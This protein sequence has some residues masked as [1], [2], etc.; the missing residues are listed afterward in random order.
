MP[1]LGDYS[2]QQ[3]IAARGVGTVTSLVRSGR[4]IGKSKGME[5][6]VDQFSQ[7]NDFGCQFL[8]VPTPNDRG[9]PDGFPFSPDVAQAPRPCSAPNRNFRA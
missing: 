1:E 3:W 6:K 2:S 7:P 4:T 5:T 8:M 9:I